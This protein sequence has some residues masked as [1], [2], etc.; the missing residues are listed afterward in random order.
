MVMLAE[1][2]LRPAELGTETY[3]ELPL[4]LYALPENPLAPRVTLCSVPL[5]PWPDE[6]TMVVPDVSFM[7]H[8]A[9][10]VLPAATPAGPSA[11][12]PST[13]DPA[14]DAANALQTNP[15]T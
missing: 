3:E 14:I 9:A 15:D 11:T 7:C 12:I 1:P 4:K 13:A 10:T 5:W 6:S 2:G 8:S